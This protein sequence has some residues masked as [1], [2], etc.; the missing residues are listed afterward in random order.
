MLNQ[1]C[2]ENLE[3]FES[4]FFM[5]NEIYSTIQSTIFLYFCLFKMTDIMTRHTATFLLT[6][7]NRLN[8]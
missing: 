5:S 4:Q 1:F 2:T 3:L 7:D 8:E 6:C